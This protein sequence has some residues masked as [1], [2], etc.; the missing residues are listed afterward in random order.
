MESAAQAQVSRRIEDWRSK[1]ID[2]SRRNNLLYFRRTQ[3]GN[4]SVS[5]PDAETVFNRLVLRRGKWEFWLPLEELQEESEPLE[6]PQSKRNQL[7]CEGLR[8]DIEQ[9][10]KNLNRRSLSDYRERGVRILYAAFGTLVWK[11]ENAEAVRSPLVLVPLEISRQS[12]RHPFSIAVPSVEEEAVLNPALQAKLQNDFKIDLPSLPEEWERQSL[13]GYLASVSEFVKDLGWK[14]EQTVEIGL[15]SFHKL[16]IYKD[17]ERNAEVIAQHPVIRAVSGDKTVSLVLPS[18]PDEEEVD[19][20]EK[21]EESFQVLDADSSQRIA[22]EYALRGQSFVMRGPPG[23]GK[24]QTIANIMAESIARGK[25]ALFVSE[26]MAALEVVYNRLKEVGLATFCLELHSDKANKQKVVAELNRC[27]DEDLRPRRLPSE[28]EFNQMVQLRERL[29]NYVAALHRRRPPLGKSAYEVLGQLAA[30]EQVPLIPVRLQNP[31]ELDLQ[32]MQMMEELMLKLRIVWQVVEEEDFP[33]RGYRGHVYNMEV[34]SEL[35]SFIDKLASATTFL[36]KDAEECAAQLGLEAPS[37]LNEVRWLIDVGN[38]A[39][40][41]PQ[42]EPHWVKNTDKL[43]SEAKAWQETCNWCRETRKSLMERCDSSFLDLPLNTSAELERAL[44]AV[45]EMTGTADAGVEEGDLLKRRLE[46]LIFL[47]DTIR[48][49]EE[50]TTNSAILGGALGLPAD[51]PSAERVRQLARIASLCHSEVKPEADWLN[52]SRLQQVQAIL[53]EMKEDYQQ[54]YSIRDRLLKLYTDGIYE[55]DLEELISRY[56]GP[57]RSTWR[58]LRP[59]FHRDRKKIAQVNRENRLPKSVLNDLVDARR[60]GELRLK[61]EAKAD[62]MRRLLGPYYREYDTDFEQAEKASAVASE[63]LALSG[64]DTIPEKLVKLASFGAEPTE[65]IKLTSAALRGSI[66]EWEEKLTNMAP[67]IPCV[68]AMRGSGLPIQQ[69][70]LSEVQKWAGELEKR[71]RLLCDRTAVILTLCRKE[72]QI[73]KEIL[74]D[75]RNAEKLQRMEAELLEQKP[76]LR[77]VFGF[78]FSGLETDWENILSVL[79][80]TQSLKELFGSRPIPKPFVDLVSSGTAEP[81][82]KL[83]KSYEEDL[84]LLGELEFRFEEELTYRGIG[85]RKASFEILQERLKTLRERADDLQVFIDFKEIRSRFRLNGFEDFFN[86]LVERRPPPGQFINVLRKAAYQEWINCIYDEDVDLG[87]FRR[88]H[89]EQLIAEFQRLDRDLIR[90]SAYRV[91]E[92]ANRRRPQEILAQ[93]VDTEIGILRR[94][95]AK[96]RRLMPI[97]RLFQVIPHLLFRLKPC[98]LMSPLSVSQFLDPDLMKFDLVLFDEA[99]QIVPED[100]VGAIYRGKTLVVAGDE[101]QLPPTSFFQKYLSDEPDWD[102]STESES[103][104]SILEEC[105][106]VG[107][108]IKMLQWHYRSRHEE[109]IAFSNSRFYD[110][111]LITFP[112]AVSKHENLGVKF[113]YIPDSVYDRGG[114]RNNLQEAEVVADLVFNHLRSYPEKTFGVVTFSLAQ[115]EAVE[116]AIEKRRRTHPQYEP[117]FKEDRLQGFFVKNLETVQGDERDVIIFSVGY[118]RDQRGQMTMNFGP[119][120]KLGGERRLNVGVTRAREKVILVSSIR[121]LDIDLNLTKAPGVLAL[122]H[123]LEYAEKGPE[124]LKPAA[125]TIGEYESPFEESVAEEIRRMGYTVV[126]QVGHSVYR[127]DLGVVDE[128][129]RFLLGVEGDGTTYRLAHSVRDRD[130]LRREVL[131][132]LGWRTHRIWSPSWVARRESEVR[133]LRAVLEEARKA[134]QTEK[135]GSEGSASKRPLPEVEVLRRTF[136]GAEGIGVPYEVTEFKASAADSLMFH[137]PESREERCRL[138]AKLVKEEGPV[139]FDYAVERLADAWGLNRIG[140]KAVNAVKDA[141]N[142]SQRKVLL[143]IRGSFLWPPQVKQVPVRV[144]VE[145]VPESRRRIEWI[146]PEEIEGALKEI[147]RRTLGIGVESLIAE[148]ARL[149]GF[150]RR[151]SRVKARIVEAYEKLLRDGEILSVN[152]RV[153]LP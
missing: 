111:R 91:I 130:R 137:L 48:S 144:P 19:S 36:R 57:Y 113:V 28:T 10:L 8:A 53:L 54:F 51:D 92:A 20:L 79:R 64:V 31:R 106:G 153:S 75:L 71:L 95:A 152:G 56:E 35:S 150:S 131:E 63:I 40:K 77:D 69:T 52:P 33:W 133:R 83:E 73:Y 87:A 109:L 120:N 7:V 62:E 107:L 38:M 67:L 59:S 5:Q 85:L 76:I 110:N 3:R 14:L 103:L 140:P 18:L 114:R 45:S 84:Q 128:P 139:H 27:L 122:R 96:K 34:H 16:V 93:A 17:L 112:S 24:S 61:I 81:P 32:R 141:A 89:H 82:S 49:A 70:P 123:Y 25:S 102:E 6:S 125:P 60:L 50:W 136:K 149:F 135:E 74:T 72:P 116:E 66:S 46:L 2:F 11:D 1:L 138:L 88:E 44:S 98:L 37:T 22:I 68:A 13:I 30:L 146:P 145:G 105:L 142:L 97:R 15:F 134:Q 127:I 39:H 12:A 41:S 115:M 101:K 78:R 124:V 80:W 86:Q 126:P 65:E 121:A 29:N 99:S 43:I 47:S 119:L 118:G 104:D 151:G 100:A 9:T 132:K 108:P 26:K 23:T 90:L 94:E 117:F 148:T 58:W 147:V 143:E 42:P 55:L 21:P 4:L 129:G